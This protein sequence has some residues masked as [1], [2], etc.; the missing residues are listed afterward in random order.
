[1]TELARLGIRIEAHGD[2][3]R[4]SPRSAV[5]PDMA[6]RMKAHKGELLGILRCD[7]DSGCEGGGEHE[8]EDAHE[9]DGKTRRFC[10]RC[11]KFGGFVLADGT[12]K[13]PNPIPKVKWAADSTTI[14]C[15]WCHGKRLIDGCSGLWC[16]ECERL[17]WFDTP[18]GGVMRA[19]FAGVEPIDPPTSCPI[20]GGSVFSWNCRGDALC[21][22]CAPQHRRSRE[23]LARTVRLR[24]RT[25]NRH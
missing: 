13:Q 20:C 21:V 3:L 16:D 2:R 23:M 9:S 14:R 24:A 6:Q 19:D 1:M 7:I 10:K 25:Q 22:N 12:I 8:W 5:T 15:P 4:Y 11:C 18:T 17:A